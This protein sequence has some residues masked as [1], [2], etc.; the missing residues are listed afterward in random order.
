MESLD[1]LNKRGITPQLLKIHDDGE[2]NFVPVMKLDAVSLLRQ[3][4]RLKKPNKIL[5]IGTATGFSGISMLSAYENAT[6]Y[7]IEH[8]ESRVKEARK[9]FEEAGFGDR[10]NFFVG[11]VHEIINYVTGEFDFLFFDGPKSHYLEFLNKLRPYLN[12]GCVLFCDNVLFRGSVSGE[13]DYVRRNRTI[14][15]NMREFLDEMTGGEW[16]TAVYDIGDG[17]SISV[18]K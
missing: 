5:E 6:L 17:V 8:N 3:T 11:D 2:K 4:V 12:P 18:L 9:N 7:T 15:N 10:V 14:V 13:C 1:E 16:D